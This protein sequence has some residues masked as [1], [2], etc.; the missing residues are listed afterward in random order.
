[1]AEPARKRRKTASPEEDEGPSSPLKQPPRRPS[2]ALHTAAGADRARSPL[3]EPPRRLSVSPRKAVYDRSSSPL[4]KPPR[5]PSFAS[6]TK[7]S[8]ARNY[9]SLLPQRPASRSSAS[10][11]RNGNSNRFA[12]GREARAYILG[13]RDTRPTST[14]EPSINGHDGQA[15]A[16]AAKATKPQDTQNVTPRAQR[17][18]TYNKAVAVNG[19]GDE[20]ADLPLTPSQRSMEKLDTP[21]RGILYS[22]PSKRPQRLKDPV[23]HSPLR[24][25][26]PPVREKEP[27]IPIDE[28]VEE[29]RAEV[30]KKKEPPNAE[31]EHRKREKDRLIQELQDLESQVSRCAE[32][33]VKIQG[34]SATHVLPPAEQDD[35]IAFI[36]NITKNPSEAEEE[37]TPTVSNLL[38]SFLPFSTRI[39]PPPKSRQSQHKPVASH[40]PL[41]L[42]NPLPYLEMFTNF[43]I[44]TQLNLPRGRVFPGSNRVHQKHIIELTGPQKLLTA[45]IAIVIDILAKTIIDLQILRLSPWAE[46]EL[47][48]FIRARAQEQNLGN[49]SWAVGT[50][51]EIAKKRAEYW[52]KCESAFA[53]L[54]PGATDRDGENDTEASKLKAIARKDFNRHLGRD[55][56]VL[57]DRHVL[58]RIMW[59][60]GFDWTGEAESDIG[61]EAAVPEVCK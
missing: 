54:I 38:C 17:T 34:P 57:Q 52:H 33:I 2:F 31:L 41:E 35:L 43:N 25:K 5:R 56:L 45:S 11:V 3:K 29:E 51:W 7:A 8:L 14:R 13:D 42:D 4:R 18:K 1:M 47:G 23:K 46:R 28:P 44:T 32:E 21:R 36:N 24:P 53:R 49:A 55:V 19:A 26:A 16:A 48:V 37:K 58:L 10:P 39:I 27:E 50:Y 61:V 59:K 6:P 60:I 30:E 15:T 20:D 9:P 40:R 12:K 22:S